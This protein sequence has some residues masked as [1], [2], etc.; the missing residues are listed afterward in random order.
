M[1][2][3]GRKQHTSWITTSCQYLLKSSLLTWMKFSLIKDPIHPLNVPL[4][5]LMPASRAKHVAS[6]F[7]GVIFAN[8]TDMGKKINAMLS[9]SP[10]VSVKTSRGKSGIPYLRLVLKTNI[11]ENGAKQVLTSASTRISVRIS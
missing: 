5:L 10:T 6:M 9:V 11:R 2:K 1:K 7:F 8:K 4:K 3:R